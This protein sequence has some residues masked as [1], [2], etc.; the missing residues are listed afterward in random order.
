MSSKHECLAIHSR[1][2]YT[3][4]VC[5]TVRMVE[6]TDPGTEPKPKGMYRISFDDGGLFTY[7]NDKHGEV[8]FDCITRPAVELMAIVQKRRAEEKADDFPSFKVSQ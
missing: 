6:S 8:C 7:S 5:G 2:T 3:C 4:D 1:T